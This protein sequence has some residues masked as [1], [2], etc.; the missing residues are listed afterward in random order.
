MITKSQRSDREM[1]WG[2]TLTVQVKDRV[3]SIRKY[4]IETEKTD[5]VSDRHYESVG[6]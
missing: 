1:D 6:L 5:P 2:V 3:V 4:V